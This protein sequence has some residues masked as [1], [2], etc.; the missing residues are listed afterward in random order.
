MPDY[1]LLPR[2]E[3]S[4]SSLFVEHAA[5]DQEDSSIVI[6]QDDGR[7]PVPVAS[8]VCLFLGPGTTITHSAVKTIAQNGCTVVWCG[9]DMMKFY[10]S[11]IGETNH[12]RNCLRQAE[13]CMDEKLHM[14]VVRRMYERRFDNP[15]DKNLSLEQLRGI[16][17]IRVREAYKQASLSTG[18]PWEGRQYSS[19]DWNASDDINKALS[20]ANSQLYGLCQSVIVALGYSTSLGFIHTGKQLSFIY[21]VADLYKADTTIPA[22][23][24][25]VQ[26]SPTNLWQEVR[27]RCRDSFQEQHILQRIPKDLNWIFQDDSTDDGSDFVGHLWDEENGETQGGINHSDQIQ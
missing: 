22:A 21:D 10:A 4:M 8:L 1:K 14:Q 12:S 13:C 19:A 17:G 26:G 24:L 20:M 7:V 6:I 25:S 18:I 9:E 11:G 2:V 23:F 16:E 15:P 5:I 3:D 27:K